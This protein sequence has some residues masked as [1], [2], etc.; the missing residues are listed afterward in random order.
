[1]KR[2][3]FFGGGV[4]A[5]RN[6]NLRPN[7][8]VDNNIDMHGDIVYGLEVKPPSILINNVQEYDIVIC[9]T[10]VGEVRKQL[11]SYGYTWDLNIRVANELTERLE[12]DNLEESKFKFLISCGLPSTADSFS[13]GGIYAISETDTYPIVNKIYEGNTHGL[14]RFENGYVFSCK[15]KGLVYLDN[16]FKEINVI[17]LRQGLRPHGIR[18]YNNLWVLASSNNDSIIAVNDKGEE[19]FEYRFSDKIDTFGSAQHHCNDLDIVGNFAYVSMFSLSG[20]WKRNCF[21]GGIMEINLLNGERRALI[22]NLTMPHN[23]TC[24][25]S[26][27]KVLNSFKGTFLA[28]NFSVLATLP[29]FVRGYDSDDTYYYLGES[30]NRNFSRIKTERTPVSIDTKITIVNKKFGFCRSIYLNKPISEIHSIIK[31]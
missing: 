31:I 7:F 24:D 3:V 4:V 1:M 10:S 8:I 20:N 26:G 9:T 23:V 18:R 17:K 12:I 28:N 5:E 22:D 21:D 14:I 16:K 13:G 19:I 11:E 6:L 29:G 30:K 15:G 2:I 27:L 25:E